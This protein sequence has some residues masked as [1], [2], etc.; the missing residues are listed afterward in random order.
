MTLLILTYLC[1]GAVVGVLAGLLGV[2]GGLV[3]V[4]MLVVCFTQ[5]DIPQES[6]MH[7]A[8]GTSAASIVFTSVSSFRAH[9][10]RGAVVWH[11][12]F[13][14]APG[15]LAGAVLGTFLASRMSTQGLK[16]FFA[17][18]LCFVA[19][20]M[21]LDRKPRPARDLPGWWGMAAVGAAIGAV[22]SLAGIG[23]GIMSVPFL[24]WC[25][26]PMHRAIGTSA[27]IGFPIALFTSLGNVFFGLHATGLPAYAVGYVYLPALACIVAAS[28]L[29]A[30]L[31][32]G[33]AHRLPVRA[34]KRVFAVLLIVVGTRM[35][36]SL[37]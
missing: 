24:L 30:P 25:N 31:G 35:L 36:L 13:R 6:L 19:L 34:L 26:Q 16:G 7:L 3:I 8:I 4:P 37:V 32:A 28:V 20:Q 10:K 18:F 11:A 14:I 5:Q 1:V 29:T 12:V 2:G 9:H 15:I 17:V 23:G 33:L 27:A 22:S 21:L